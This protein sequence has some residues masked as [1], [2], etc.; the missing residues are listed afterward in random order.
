M[1]QMEIDGLTGIVKFDEEG[2]RS[3]FEV[4]VL[5]VMGH[6]FEKVGFS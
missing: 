4:D 5:E 6:G 3:D 1:L 2:T